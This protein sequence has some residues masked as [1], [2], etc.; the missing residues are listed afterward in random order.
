MTSS[1]SRT[2]DK[3]EGVQAV[4]EIEK[5]LFTDNVY[6]ITNYALSQRDEVTVYWE[7]LYP[8]R[9][10][11][12]RVTESGLEIAFV[13]SEAVRVEAV[14]AYRNKKFSISGF[15]HLAAGVFFCK[16]DLYM[17][18]YINVPTAAGRK[19]ITKYIIDT[20]NHLY[21]EHKDTW[22]YYLRRAGVIRAHERIH[23][24]MRNREEV[25]KKLQEINE[26]IAKQ[27]ATII[28]LIGAK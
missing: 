9:S 17:G 8:N 14:V 22:D 12:R 18:Y 7:T 5:E 26:E 10:N 11:L 4:E 6:L 27:A 20:I 28:E 3:G 24:E 25:L 15:L 1:L 2:F 23:S 16:E 19:Y 13:A 21:S